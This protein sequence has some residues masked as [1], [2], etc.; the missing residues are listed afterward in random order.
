VEEINVSTENVVKFSKH[1]FSMYNDEVQSY[2]KKNGYDKDRK[3]ILL[4]G[5][6]THICVLQTAVH[7]LHAG[8]NVYLVTDAASSQRDEDRS[9]AM[10]RLKSE[11]VKLTTSESIFYEVLGDSKHEKFKQILP[12]VKQLSDFKKKDVAQT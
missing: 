10:E 12:I 6:E 3:N 9:I 8:Y 2:I 5:I 1:H 7:L 11:G 4:Y